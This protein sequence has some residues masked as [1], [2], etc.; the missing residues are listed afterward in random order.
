MWDIVTLAVDYADGGV[1]F[2]KFDVDDDYRR[3]RPGHQ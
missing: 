1:G 2:S 3:S